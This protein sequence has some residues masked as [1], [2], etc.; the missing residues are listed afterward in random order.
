MTNHLSALIE[1]VTHSLSS[2]S[3]LESGLI[4]L[5]FVLLIFARKIISGIYSE[6][7]TENHFSYRVNTLRSLNIIIIFSLIYFIFESDKNIHNPVFKFISI[8]LLIYFS[9]LVSHIFAFII[10]R[11][12]GKKRE[13]EGRKKIIETYRSRLLTLLSSIGIFIITLIS[14]IQIMEFESLLQA[15]GVIG[16]IGVF[17]A[18][19]QNSWAPDIFSGLI[20]LNSG[21]IEEGDVIQFENN[22]FIIGIIYKTK[23]FHT[24]ILNLV[25]NHRIMLKNSNLRNVTIHNLSKFASAKGLRENLHFKISYLESTSSIKSM[26]ENAFEKS[27]ESIGQSIEFQYPL[28]ISVYD[29]G[30]H[31]IEWAVYY[32]T[33]DVKNLI[34]TRHELRERIVTEANKQGIDLSTPITHSDARQLTGIS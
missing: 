34:K 1:S 25:N 3:W 26:F 11:N 29:T 2:L 31:A 33:K 10:R 27:K 15:G 8:S 5:N 7:S 12:Y 16:F 30:D 14:I 6:P 20:I 22:E 13:V 17:L 18:L 19:T 23:I 9:F 28:E 4:L 32:Y 24:E 21:M